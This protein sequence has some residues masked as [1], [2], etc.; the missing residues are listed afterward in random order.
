MPLRENA[1]HTL[2]ARLLNGGPADPLP[3]K[4]V[5]RTYTI[6]MRVYGNEDDHK[7]V[8]HNVAQHAMALD[9]LNS[10]IDPGGKTIA[11]CEDWFGG[12]TEI[13]RVA[14]TEDCTLAKT[15]SAMPFGPAMDIVMA[16]LRANKKM[17]AHPG[18]MGWTKRN[19]TLIAAWSAAKSRQR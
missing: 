14:R 16:L 8:K 10:E 9:V 12:H 5:D 11:H 2:L 6:E 15:L 1:L 18:I 7:R 3:P 17:I 19:A 13:E 4:K